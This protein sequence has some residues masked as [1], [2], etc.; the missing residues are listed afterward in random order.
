[1]APPADSEAMA[2][3]AME[4]DNVHIRRIAPSYRADAVDQSKGCLAQA[5]ANNL[6]S[7]SPRGARI[8][9]NTRQR[10]QRRS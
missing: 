1:M 10:R 7:L 3:M 4:A 9:H 2:A 6:I 5:K 8:P